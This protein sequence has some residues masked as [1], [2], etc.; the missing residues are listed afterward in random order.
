[1]RVVTQNLWGRR[2][3]WSARRAVLVEGLCELD[4]DLVALPEAVVN[5]EYTR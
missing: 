3:D 1:M 2:G 5:Q 4:R